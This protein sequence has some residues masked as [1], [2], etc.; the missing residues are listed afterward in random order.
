MALCFIENR[1]LYV[2]VISIVMENGIRFVTLITTLTPFLECVLFVLS[3][4]H[5]L[6]VPVPSFNRGEL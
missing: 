6:V 2:I 5:T 3:V 4:S 1:D